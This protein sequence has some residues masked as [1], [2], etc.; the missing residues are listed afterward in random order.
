MFLFI[1]FFNIDNNSVQE[2]V[3]IHENFISHTSTYQEIDP[4]T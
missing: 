2:A 4:E 3:D 1:I